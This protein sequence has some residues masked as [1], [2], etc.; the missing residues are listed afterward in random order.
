MG[1]TI[2]WQAA[3]NNGDGI[4]VVALDIA[5][6]FGVV[7][8]SALLPKLESNRIKGSSLAVCR[9]YIG[10]RKLK[11]VI[12]RHESSYRKIGANVPQG[13]VFGL[14]LWNIFFNCLLN[15]IHKVY[16][17]AV[18]YTLSFRYKPKNRNEVTQTVNRA[19]KKIQSV[20]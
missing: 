6:A 13:G 19:F 14:L 1:L 11:V 18:G 9:D 3:L 16:A 12:S 20:V 10:D 8:H 15:L 5:G 4:V 17:Y 7:W 2:E